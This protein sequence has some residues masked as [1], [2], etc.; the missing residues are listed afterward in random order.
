MTPTL[1]Q[2]LFP[3]HP[4]FGGRRRLG[5][6]QDEDSPGLARIGEDNVA[7]VGFHDP[8]TQREAQA[9]P[10]FSAGEKGIENI[11]GRV[12]GDAGAIIANGEPAFDP[13]NGQGVGAGLLRVSRHVQ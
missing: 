7:A 9:R 12:S 11:V 10:L 13:T 1:P 2:R 6:V 8:S 3:L 4:V 5:Q